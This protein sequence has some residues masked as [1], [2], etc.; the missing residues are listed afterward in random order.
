MQGTRTSESTKMNWCEA[1]KPFSWTGQRNF[2]V[3]R[4]VPAI[5]INTLQNV[6]H[7]HLI[8]KKSLL[9]IYILGCSWLFYSN[10]FYTIST[11]KYIVLC[12]IITLDSTVYDWENIRPGV[13]LLM[14]IWECAD[15]CKGCY[16]TP[17]VQSGQSSA[18]LKVL[19][20]P[21]FI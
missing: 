6:L 4:S 10:L 5:I 16:R 18:C 17:L 11:S 7:S 20:I 15:D 8:F 13:C 3:F 2:H 21:F 12:Y 14:V 1:A 19:E 9:L